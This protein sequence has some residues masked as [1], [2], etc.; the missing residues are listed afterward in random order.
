MIALSLRNDR[1][2]APRYGGVKD[3]RGHLSRSPGFCCA[4]PALLLASGSPRRRELLA[5]LGIAFEV[6]IPDVQEHTVGSGNAREIALR[7]ARMKAEAVAK[8]RQ[9]KVIVAADTVV[10]LRGK[11]MGKPLDAVAAWAMLDTL[12]SQEHQVISGLAVFDPTSQTIAL[13]AVETQVW[14]RNYQDQDISGYIARG[15]PFDKAGGYAIQDQIFHPVER[16]E[17]CYT[18]VMGLPLC[19]LYLELEEMGFPLL[20]SPLQACEAYIRQP[21]L[22]AAQILKQGNH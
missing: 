19:H 7:L 10:A 22:V 20:T 18:N 16:I 21:C 5:L 1:A 11:A 8:I 12:R 17:G 3:T 13:Q 2:Q 14:M 15:E 4:M 6:V 9:R